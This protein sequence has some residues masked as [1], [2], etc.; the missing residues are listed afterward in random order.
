MFLLLLATVFNDLTSALYCY[1]NWYA[2]NAKVTLFLNLFG[3]FIFFTATSLI[4][5]I[6]YSIA[7]QAF[8]MEKLRNLNEKPNRE[9]SLNFNEYISEFSD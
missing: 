9:T 4:L 8:T 1:F 5:Y 2:R 3:N 6:C 7:Q